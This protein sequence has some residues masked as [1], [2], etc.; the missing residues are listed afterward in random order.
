[1]SLSAWLDRNDTEQALVN[2]CERYVFLL[3]SAYQQAHDEDGHLQVWLEWAR[4]TQVVDALEAETW[5]RAMV[6]RNAITS[7]NEYAIVLRD[8]IRHTMK[9][10]PIV[11][12][13]PARIAA[14]RGPTNVIRLRP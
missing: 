10:R 4:K 13:L 11:E 1:M 2:M 8:I 14:R 5:R 9:L 12:M 7:Q 6:V 3:S